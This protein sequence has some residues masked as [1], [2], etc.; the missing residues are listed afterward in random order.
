MQEIYEDG[1]VGKVKIADTLED[2]LPMIKE[3]LDHPRVKY[4]KVFN[5]GKKVQSEETRTTNREVMEEIMQFEPEQNVEK[6]KEVTRTFP[7]GRR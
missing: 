2:L 6:L 3:S 5:N 1:S 4:V 7:S